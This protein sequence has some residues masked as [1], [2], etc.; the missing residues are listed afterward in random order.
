MF[1]LLVGE[2]IGRLS[3]TENRKL[4]L[5]SILLLPKEDDDSQ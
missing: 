3:V 5:W 1:H 4:G 2:L